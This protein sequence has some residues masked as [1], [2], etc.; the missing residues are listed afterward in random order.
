[1]SSTVLLPPRTQLCIRYCSNE[2]QG[3]APLHGPEVS[4]ELVEM[5]LVDYHIEH[6]VDSVQFAASGYI[7]VFKFVV[8]RT[9][10]VCASSR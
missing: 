8:P 2:Q 10:R 6:K 7:S 3:K 4:A 9:H 5:T 1:M